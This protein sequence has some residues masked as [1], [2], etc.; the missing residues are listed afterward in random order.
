MECIVLAPIKLTIFL[1]G[2]KQ[3]LL[4]QIQ[5]LPPEGIDPFAVSIADEVPLRFHHRLVVHRADEL[6]V[7]NLAHRSFHDVVAV[8]YPYFGPKADIECLFHATV[9]LKVL[10]LS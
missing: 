9:C 5:I 4:F 2:S 1:Q 10:L 6:G 7:P 3:I 8:N